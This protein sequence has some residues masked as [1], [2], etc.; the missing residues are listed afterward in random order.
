MKNT[1]KEIKG[2]VEGMTLTWNWTAD[3]EPEKTESEKP[4]DQ[5]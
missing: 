4:K 1:L 2:V 3:L 5:H